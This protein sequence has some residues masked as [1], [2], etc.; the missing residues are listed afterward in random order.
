M[1]RG[2]YVAQP[3]Y[4]GGIGLI[5]F[6]E[7]TPKRVIPIQVKARARSCYN[8]QRVWFA[9]ADGIALVQV[10]NLETQP[11]CYIFASLDQVCEALGDHANSISW[12]EKGSYNVT[13]PTDEH[14]R[15]M[16]SHGDRW[17]RI[18]NQL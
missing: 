10:W 15:R 2:V 12:K 14:I 13:H 7:E 11:L 5:A 3:A 6:R 18:I 9:K 8:F 16:E 1:R 4:D 17:D